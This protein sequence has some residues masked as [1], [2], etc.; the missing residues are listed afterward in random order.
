VD[1]YKEIEQVKGLYRSGKARFGVNLNIIYD[2]DDNLDIKI[3]V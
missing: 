3:Q 2:I 1:I